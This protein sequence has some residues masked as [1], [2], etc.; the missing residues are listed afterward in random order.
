MFFLVRAI[1]RLQHRY[2][3]RDAVGT[4]GLVSAQPHRL[5]RRHSYLLL[6]PGRFPVL[7][8]D[9][10]ELFI[11]RIPSRRLLYFL[12]RGIGTGIHHLR[13]S[14]RVRSGIRILPQRDLRLHRLRKHAG[15]QR[16]GFDLSRHAGL[17]ERPGRPGRK[18]LSRLPERALG[19]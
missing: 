14:K 7:Q 8:R 19:A 10:H 4:A 9:G 5:F 13:M 3:E 16:H 2:P 17:L 18:H 6:Q 1:G 12:P 15:R 11:G